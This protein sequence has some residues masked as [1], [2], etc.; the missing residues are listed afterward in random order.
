MRAITLCQAL[1][2]QRAHERRIRATA[3]LDQ[4]SHGAAARAAPH[5]ARHYEL[6]A[7]SWGRGAELIAAQPVDLPP[8]YW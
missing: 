8:A 7:A 3:A 6:T 5:I 2:A 1:V 4:R